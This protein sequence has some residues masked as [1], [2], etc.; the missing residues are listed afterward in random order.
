[1]MILLVFA[2][3]LDWRSRYVTDAKPIS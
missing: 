3:V 1:M 2:L